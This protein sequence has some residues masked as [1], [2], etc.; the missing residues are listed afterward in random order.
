[1][2]VL[3]EGGAGQRDAGVQICIAGMWHTP[4]H[5]LGQFFEGWA[6]EHHVVDGA[7][8]VGHLHG[9]RHVLQPTVLGGGGAPGGM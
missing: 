3:E 7:G 8:C 4:E 9:L 5:S 1:M 6:S 2:L